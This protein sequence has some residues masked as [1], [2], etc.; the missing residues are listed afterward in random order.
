MGMGAINGSIYGTSIGVSTV[1]TRSSDYSTDELDG[2]S[3]SLG[4][5]SRNL[6]L[7]NCR[8]V[9]SRRFL[10]AVDTDRGNGKL[11]LSYEMTSGSRPVN[12]RRNEE[13]DKKLEATGLLRVQ[14]SGLA[15]EGYGGMC[16]GT[17]IADRDPFLVLSN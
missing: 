6:R 4:E 12:R 9:L 8:Q 7:H 10:L 13:M 16:H 2:R 5:T 17:Y 3:P 15:N 11:K 14:A 1:D